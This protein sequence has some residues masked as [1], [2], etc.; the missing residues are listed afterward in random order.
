MSYGAMALARPILRDR[1]GLLLELGAPSA[2]DLIVLLLIAVAAL[3]VSAIPAW[4]AYRRT[5]AD[6]LTMRV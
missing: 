2:S 4:Q 3:L 1:F 5:L 6:G